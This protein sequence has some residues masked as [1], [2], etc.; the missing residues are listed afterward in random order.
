MGFASTLGNRFKA[1]FTGRFIAV[2]SGAILTVLLA[3]LLDPDGY[4]LFYLSLSIL[5]SVQ[6]L[7]RL[8]IPKSAARYITEYKEQDPSQ[9]RHIIVFS[10]VLNVGLLAFVSFALILSAEWIAEFMGE[11]EL[12]LLLLIGVLHIIFAALKSYSRSI[13][14]GF[15]AI[16]PAAITYAVDNST[17][18]LLAVGLVVLGYGAVGAL[19]GYV[20]AHVIGTVLGLGYIYSRFYRSLESGVVKS[21][22]RRRITEYSVSLAGTDTA[23]V[24]DKRVD[25]ILVGFF[26]GPI[27]VAYYTIGKQVIS[28]VKTPISA[29]GFS[30]SPT[31]EAERAKGNPDTAVKLYEEALSHSLLLY[32]PAAAGLILVAEPL[33]ELVFG[34][35]YLGAVLVLQILALYVVLKSVTSLTSHTLDFLGRARERAIIKLI[36]AVLNILLNILLIP[37]YGVPGAALATV[38]TFS[39]YTFVNLY[40]MHDELGLRVHVLF[41]HVGVVSAITAVMSAVVYSLLGFVTGFVT[42]LLV[43][44]VGVVVWAV[45][46]IATGLLDLNRLSSTLA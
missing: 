33:V 37:R 9:I 10:L 26:V 17:R 19:V 35:D 3:R 28:F 20:L 39:L 23:T 40:I 43:V 27:G 44:G 2:A 41:N 34:T 31:I 7:G 6:L 11:P 16:K 46:S 42:L 5:G 29:L 4:G 22:I 18:L 24:L 45:L 15:E 30:I 32:I 14:Q 8:G 12:T 38:I 25:T 21:G 1:E 36:S 13:L